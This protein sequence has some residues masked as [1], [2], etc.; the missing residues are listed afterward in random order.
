MFPR[1]LARRRADEVV[2]R[3]IARTPRPAAPPAMARL[4]RRA[5][6]PNSTTG[7]LR[8]TMSRSARSDPCIHGMHD[9]GS[10]SLQGIAIANVCHRDP[11]G[12]PTRR[13]LRRGTAIT[14]GPGVDRSDRVA[15][16]KGIIPPHDPAST[17]RCRSAQTEERYDHDPMR[18]RARPDDRRGS[19]RPL[20]RAHIT[21]PPRNR[22]QDERPEVAKV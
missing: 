2:D 16:T 21:A 1:T 12:A 22:P 19:G 5:D 20:S 7:V 9:R 3:P 14:C 13:R 17:T 10:S 18:R 4:P 15:T 11:Q 8:I 6:P